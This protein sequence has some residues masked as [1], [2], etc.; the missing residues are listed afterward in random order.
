[1]FRIYRG[2]QSIDDYRSTSSELEFQ[3]Q[4]LDSNNQRSIAWVTYEEA[5]MVATQCDL[6]YD[7]MLYVYNQNDHIIPRI[8]DIIDKKIGKQR[9]WSCKYT[10]CSKSG[11]TNESYFIHKDIHPPY[12]KYIYHK[13]D[14]TDTLIKQEATNLSNNNEDIDM[15]SERKNDLDIEMK[16]KTTD[17]R[18]RARKLRYVYKKKN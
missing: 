18:S 17:N 12:N 8:M 2:L 6:I 7:L 16:D 15:T 5:R 13:E 11:T 10:D 14:S 3:V 9:V 4:Y 1:M